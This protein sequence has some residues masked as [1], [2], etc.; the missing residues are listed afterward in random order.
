MWRETKTIGRAALLLAGALTPLTALAQEEGPREVHLPN[1]MGAHT[2]F[3]IVAVGAFLAWCISFALQLQRERMTGHPR[4]QRESLLRRKDE[5]LDSLAK[6]ESQKDA[7]AIAQSR[8]E[9]DLKK[10]RSQLSDVLGRLKSRQD[11]TES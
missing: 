6:L 8:Y 1:P 7:G 3:I 4:P 2:W 11:P 9:K 10:L 5:L